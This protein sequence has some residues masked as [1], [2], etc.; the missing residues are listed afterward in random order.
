MGSALRPYS[1]AAQD[2]RAERE[3]AA[4][5]LHAAAVVAA[6]IRAAGG[7]FVQRQPTREQ[8][9]T[10]LL[11]VLALKSRGWLGS[12]AGQSVL[13]RHSLTVDQ[14][15]AWRAASEVQHG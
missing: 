5:A 3:E 14:V 2:S 15:E 13:Q 1:S 11:D 12:W 4:R 10:G 6:L 9:C 8:C 7:P